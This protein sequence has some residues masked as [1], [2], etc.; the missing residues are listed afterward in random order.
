MAV[1]TPPQSPYYQREA[2]TRLNSRFFEIFNLRPLAIPSRISFIL[3]TFNLKALS[4]I[5]GHANTGFV[6]VKL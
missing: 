3:L 2:S 5:S 4:S 6:N 1:Y